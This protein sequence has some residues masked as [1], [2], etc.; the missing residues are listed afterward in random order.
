MESSY[1]YG[2]N[3]LLLDISFHN[4]A[5][6]MIENYIWNVHLLW[7]GEMSFTEPC[8][9]MKTVYQGIGIYIKI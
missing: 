1:C 2:Y 6:L 5:W 4:L 9:N 7:L 3:G 8:F